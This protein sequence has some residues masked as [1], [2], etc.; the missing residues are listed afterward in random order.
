MTSKM[1]FMILNRKL[2]TYYFLTFYSWTPSATG[3]VSHVERVDFSLAPLKLTF[4][5]VVTALLFNQT[6]LILS[7]LHLHSTLQISFRMNFFKLIPTRRWTLR[8]LH[9]L[10]S[11]PQKNRTIFVSSDHVRVLHFVT[12]MRTVLE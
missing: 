4:G 10:P 7:H 12:L 11:L 8:H 9:P 2:I 6:P 3:S 1:N 5:P